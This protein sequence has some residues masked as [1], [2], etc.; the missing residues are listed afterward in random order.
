MF[1]GPR[2]A[3]FTS[4]GLRLLACVETDVGEAWGRKKH[5]F[6]NLMHLCGHG[7]FKSS[8]AAVIYCS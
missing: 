7:L 2:Q 3:L 1:E 6:M 8:K 5:D 4:F